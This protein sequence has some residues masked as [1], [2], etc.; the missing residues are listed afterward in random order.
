MVQQKIL[1]DS[2]FSLNEAFTRVCCRNNY[3]LRSKGVIDASLMPLLANVVDIR[4]V[5]IYGSVYAIAEIAVCLAY[6]IG[7]LLGGYLV[8]VM[9]FTWVMR[10]IGILNLMYCPLCYFLKDI[11]SL[12]DEN[13]AINLKGRDFDMKKPSSKEE[14]RTR[15]ASFANEE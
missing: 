11:P 13:M 15:Y 7:P 10:S 4:Y 5:A 3:H 14:G 1:T 9:G 2:I 6:S 12:E 8:K